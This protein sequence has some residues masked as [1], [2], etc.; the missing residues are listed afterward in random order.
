[1]ERN[2]TP[3]EKK[4]IY[5]YILLKTCEKVLMLFKGKYFQQNLKVQA[6]LKF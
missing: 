2:K 1:M 6:F 5:I 4:Y 3:R